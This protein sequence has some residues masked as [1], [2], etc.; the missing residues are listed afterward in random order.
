MS[1]EAL[2]WVPLTVKAQVKPRHRLRE[3]S[4]SIR[5]SN[6]IAMNRPAENASSATANHRCRLDQHGPGDSL[7]SIA[8]AR[9]DSARPVVSRGA[10]REGCQPGCRRCPHPMPTVRMVGRVGDDAFAERLL[11][12]L[13]REGIDVSQVR[14]TADTASGL[15]IVNVDDQGENSILV[16]PGANAAVSPADVDLA[17]ELIESSDVL[18]LQLEI[19]IPAVLRA[20][21]S[22]PPGRRDSN[23]C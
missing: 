10:R 13:L 1:S 18:L 22:C 4:D 17:A 14:R 3:C 2:S 21:E 15:A 6:V 16:V 5:R 23:R 12:N 8:S 20:I 11:D 7:C 19:G 9:R